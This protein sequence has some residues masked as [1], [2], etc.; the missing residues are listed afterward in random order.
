MGA[1]RPERHSLIR[2]ELAG[3]L[4]VVIGDLIPAERRGQ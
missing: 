4:E 1:R 3:G 2:L